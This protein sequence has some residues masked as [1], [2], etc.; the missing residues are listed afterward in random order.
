MEVEV[1]KNKKPEIAEKV[2]KVKSRYSEK[3]KSEIKEKLSFCTI[4]QVYLM[5]EEKIPHNTLIDWK[6]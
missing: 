5:Y 2:M 1:K 4:H 6:R 3:I